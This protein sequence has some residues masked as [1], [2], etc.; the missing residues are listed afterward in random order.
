MSMQEAEDAVSVPVES[1]SAQ[2]G[3][4]GG[5][6]ALTSPGADGTDQTP[7][8]Q[9]P[10]SDHRSEA[11]EADVACAPKRSRSKNWHPHECVAALWAMIAASDYKQQQTIPV[12]KKYAADHYLS[13]AQTL[14]RD[15]PEFWKLTGGMSPQQSADHRAINPSGLWD[16]ADNVKTK[17]GKLIAL[18]QGVVNEQHSGWSEDQIIAEA[19]NRYCVPFWL[20][21][22]TALSR[23]KSLT[24][25]MQMLTMQAL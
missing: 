15:H 9:S 6:V 10:G 20:G 25:V 1:L 8:P 4:T 24:T 12:M 22:Y 2:G 13:K 21:L 14:A 16:K 19:K 23:Q 5:A 18:Y 17:V 11:D 3:S 7:G